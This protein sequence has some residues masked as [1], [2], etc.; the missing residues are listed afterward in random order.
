MEYK[1]LTCEDCDFFVEEKGQ[2]FK[3]MYAMAR[4]KKTCKMNMVRRQRKYII[5]TIR[6]ADESLVKEIFNMIK[7]N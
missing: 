3:P 2:K 6:D 4:H 1:R 5:E 7:Q